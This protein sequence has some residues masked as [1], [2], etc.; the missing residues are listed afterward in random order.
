MNFHKYLLLL[1]VGTL[2]VS[3]EPIERINVTGHAL[4]K[5]L[6]QRIQASKIELSGDELNNRKADTLG[7]TLSQLPGVDSGFLVAHRVGHK[8]VDLVETGLKCCSM[9]L[10]L[11][12]CRR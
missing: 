7:E 12:I 4:E 1:G 5:P 11:R 2:A 8:S 9:E 3:A 10:K 6:S